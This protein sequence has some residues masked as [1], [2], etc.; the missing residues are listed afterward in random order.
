MAE[1]TLQ[2]GAT[3]DL[4]SGG[5]IR[6]L[7]DQLADRLDALNADPLMERVNSGGL[8]VSAAGTI[9]GGAGGTGVPIFICPQNFAARVVRVTV[10]NPLATPAAPIAA[11]WLQGFVDS[12]TVPGDLA[13]QTP[14]V[15]STTVAPVILS[16]GTS[17][18]IMLRDQQQLVVVG[19]G[20]T[21][22]QVY[23]IGLQVWL[24]PAP[25]KP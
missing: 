20:L 12:A 3:F 4:A 10:N 23:S 22:G 24:Y 6:D 5:E 7:R 18:A 25:G 9:G 1:V 19:G 15:G 8:T 14:A 2:A 16:D 11:G 21:S 17:S 13:F